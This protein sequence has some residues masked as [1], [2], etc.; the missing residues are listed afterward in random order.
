[1]GLLRQ[2]NVPEMRSRLP[3][4]AAKTAGSGGQDCDT[5]LYC[6]MIAYQVLFSHRTG[7]PKGSLPTSKGCLP[8]IQDL[9]AVAQYRLRIH[10]EYS[11]S[12]SHSP[13]QC[14][15]FLYKLSRTARHCIPRSE[16]CELEEYN[17]KSSTLRMNCTSLCIFSHSPGPL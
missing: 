3:K 10:R 2:L 7:G 15:N 1:M 16:P 5:Q 17:Y 11:G 6:I 8:P 13:L 9:I 14:C 12:V 4:A